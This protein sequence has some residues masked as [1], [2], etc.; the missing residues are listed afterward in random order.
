MSSN[1]RFQ[2]GSRFSE[3]EESVGHHGPASSQ[4]QE[5]RETAVKA[6]RVCVDDDGQPG[7]RQTRGGKVEAEKPVWLLAEETAEDRGRTGW[8]RRR[9]RDRKTGHI[10]EGVQ[11]VVEYYIGSVN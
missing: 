9:K 8:L 7:Q 5:R 3:L 11:C 4:T 10:S 2:H 6:F 1:F